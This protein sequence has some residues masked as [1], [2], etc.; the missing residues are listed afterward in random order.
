MTRQKPQNV[1]TQSQILIDYHGRYFVVTISCGERIEPS[2]REERVVTTSADAGIPILNFCRLQS[3]TMLELS[4][5]AI[6]S[7]K[8]DVFR[9]LTAMENSRSSQRIHEL[10]DRLDFLL[11]FR[12]VIACYPCVIL[13]EMT[14]VQG[15]VRA[16]DGIFRGPR[17]RGPIT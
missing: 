4:H 14:E 11:L 10:A 13:G 16:S 12:S 7:A 2:N 9:L 15:T 17:A 6:I 1:V 5:F 3:R 8:R